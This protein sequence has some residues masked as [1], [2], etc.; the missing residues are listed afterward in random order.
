MC[1]GVMGDTPRSHYYST[2]F[3][4]RQRRCGE[5]GEMRQLWVMMIAKSMA[6]EDFDGEFDRIY[7]L[8]NHAHN[9]IVG[10]KL[11][12][13]DYDLNLEDP[14]EVSK[15]LGFLAEPGLKRARFEKH[16]HELLQQIAV[17]EDRATDHDRTSDSF[18]S[19][20]EAALVAADNFGA[21]LDA[22]MP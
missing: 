14:T 2:L 9:A 7:E 11:D 16:A 6:Y 13:D 12:V 20:A 10:K 8:L 5:H 17:F 4:L 3:H 19:M 22:H 1:V 21:W 18:F 15:L